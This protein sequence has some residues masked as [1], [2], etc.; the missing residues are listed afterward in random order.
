MNIGVIYFSIIILFVTFLFGMLVGHILTK[1]D[2][3]NEKNSEEN[4]WNEY[5]FFTKDE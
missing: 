2:Y 1:K 4:Y 3:D 5:E